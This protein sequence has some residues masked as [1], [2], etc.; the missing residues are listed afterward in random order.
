MANPGEVLWGLGIMCDCGDVVDIILAI[1]GCYR[2]HTICHKV[3]SHLYYGGACVRMY[4][5]YIYATFPNEHCCVAEQPFS[6]KGM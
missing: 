1:G 2:R 5:S 3:T 4:Y 6:L